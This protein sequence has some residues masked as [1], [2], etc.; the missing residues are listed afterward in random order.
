M[1]AKSSSK[2]DPLTTYGW[3]EWVAHTNFSFLRGASHPHE[4]VYRAIDYGYRGLAITD[5]DGVYGIARTYRA[6]QK[7]KALNLEHRLQLSYGAEVHL[8]KDHDRPLV[9]QDT[10][11]LLAQSHRGYFNLCTLLTQAYSRGKKD[12]VIS[13]MDLLA[14]D[15]SDVVAVQPMR[16][17]LRSENF[18]A[19][20]QRVGLLSEHF[21]DRF[22]LTVSRLLNAFEDQWIPPTLAAARYSNTK[23]LLSQDL[24]FHSKERKPLCDLLQA[25]RL[26]QTLDQSTSHFFSN[27]ARRLL[28]LH[29][30]HKL[31]RGLPCY[32]DA[33]R[34]SFELAQS[35]RF[36]LDCLRYTYPQEM[37]PPGHTAQSFLEVLVHKGMRERY[38]EHNPQKVRDL[39]AHELDFIQT[40]GFADYFLTVWDM[41]AWARSQGILCQGRG[42]AANSAVCYVLGITAINPDNFELLFERFMS[43]E[44]GDPPDIDVDFEHERREE[45]IQYIYRR[46]GRH[47]AAMVCNVICFKTKG[48]V[49]AV[50]KAL[51][52]DEALLKESARYL[53]RRWQRTTP[54]NKTLEKLQTESSPPS[55]YRF[56]LWEKFAAELRG[57]PRHLGIHAGGFVLSAKPIQWLVP[58]EPATME[59]RTV[60]PWC[61]EDIEDLG[62]FKVDVLALGMLTAIRK[63]LHLIATHENK[64]LTLATIPADDAPTYHMMAR[65]DT[66]G[67]FQIESRAQIS[68]LPKHL[69]R[70]FYDLVVQVAIIRP[71]PI[72]G[73]MVSSYLKRRCGR[74]RVEI[75]D[76]RLEKILGRTYGVPIFQEQVMRVAMAVGGFTG[77]EANE[78]RKNIGSFSLKGNVELWVGKLAVGLRRE[79]MSEA[80][81]EGM[82]GQMRGFASYGFPE[83]HAASF[84]LLAYASAY[85]KC[86]H[87]PAF[88]AA[89]LNSQPMG[90]YTPDT[91]IKRARHLGIKILP[92]CLLV[93]DWDATLVPMPAKTGQELAI[94]LGLHRVAD[95]SASSV[96]RYLEYRKANGIA[97]SLLQILQQGFFNRRDLTALAAA[98]ALQSLGFERRAALWLVEALPYCQFLDNLQE[99]DPI[100]ILAESPW[101]AVQID[102]HTT[103]TSLR[104]HPAQ[105]LKEKEAWAYTLPVQQLTTGAELTT[106]KADSWVDLFGLVLVRQ[107]PPTAK[108]MMFITLEDETP[109]HM[110]LVVRPHI[111]ER[112]ATLIDRQVF[113]CVQGRVQN[114]DG[115]I[116]VLLHHVYEPTSLH[117]MQLAQKER[118]KG[119]GVDLF[120]RLSRNYT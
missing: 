61:K 53:R 67:V 54:V 81:V 98:G 96:Q 97:T 43:L 42:S 21:K 10:L 111:Y 15:T 16:G 31:Y 2:Q 36:S 22:Y 39:I 65:A 57:F 11:V 4:L 88:F 14:A 24:F 29:S 102:Y 86:H 75:P 101:E 18:S 50:G 47:R 69:P 119:M 49:R 89:L 7:R 40:M 76:P 68:F 52:F 90:F 17:L 1:R 8:Q 99:E 100:A 71:G 38:G 12:P 95:L 85:L 27:S 19:F 79:G 72:E 116:T 82:M 60:I 34:H 62:F 106:R 58:V 13:L 59:G 104:I 45:V 48:A 112:Y 108:G 3:Y 103:G 107:A 118:E 25:I 110:N 56:D 70:N 84:A 5:Y 80:F 33:L 32:A 35:M 74:E 77:G 9:L 44:R 83:S 64:T 66:I 73:G 94:R 109:N 23:I 37:I 92:V 120:D 117:E 55:E 91:L 20:R 41:V 51:G 28:P 46:Y 114:S 63:C 6:L 30:I 113:L 78:L 115:A 87:A 26:N 93:S 105:L